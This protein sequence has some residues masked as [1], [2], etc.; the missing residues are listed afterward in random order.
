MLLEVKTLRQV[1]VRNLAN[2]LGVVTEIIEADQI[3]QVNDTK[4][5]P[6]GLWYFYNDG[7]IEGSKVKVIRDI[8]FMFKARSLGF[9]LQLF[10]FGIPSFTKALNNSV[11]TSSRNSSPS[12][13]GSPL[14]G[15]MGHS[16]MGG[17]GDY[18]PSVNG[19]M[20]SASLSQLGIKTGG[21]LFGDA[22]GGMSLTSIFD[23]SFLDGLFDSMVDNL[24]GSLF[25]KLSYVVGFD[26]MSILGSLFGIFD[27][28]NFDSLYTD[29]LYNYGFDM[30]DSNSS[31]RNWWENVVDEYFKYHGCNGQMITKSFGDLTW[32]QDAYYN[33][34]LL[35]SKPVQS[36]V[37]FNRSLYNADYS[38][39]EEAIEKTRESLN[40]KIDRMDWF[41]NFNRYRL[42]HPDYHLTNSKAYVFMT[43]PDL[44]ILDGFSNAMNPEIQNTNKAAFFYSNALKHP[45]ICRSL[46]KSFAAN[47]DFIPLVCNTVRSLDIADETM[48][49]LEHGETLTGWKTVYARHN[50]DSKTAGTF[51]MNFIDDNHISIFTLHN[52]WHEYMNAVSRGLFSPKDGYKRNLELDYAVSVYYFLAAE[53]SQRLL[54]WTKYIGVLPT[55]V[56]SSAFSFSEGN[57][58]RIPELSLSYAY[59]AKETCD[60]LTLAEFNHNS[61]GSFNYVP[62]YNDKTTRCNP[63]IV[64]SPF[65]D[66]ND[67]GVT[68]NL[69]FREK[70]S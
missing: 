10:G 14:L 53:D 69:R 64:G 65:I 50:I 32:T 22:L 66:T 8:E 38:E 23:G 28:L 58:I 24:L 4:R 47:H 26:V 43:R 13:F 3:I 67:G 61:R 57:P 48:K 52:I 54:F 2:K 1:G 55:N 16:G 20:Q 45:N 15:G 25:N 63:T 11:Q 27:G 42:T 60:P 18:A 59:S 5:Q 35:S 17:T 41:V 68:Y 21:G 44:N 56:P 6:D 30:F 37:D 62:A 40:L 70:G 9:D 31:E 12:Q 51:N 46:T 7:W 49:T 36:E 34:P 39:L 19:D 33:T 29:L